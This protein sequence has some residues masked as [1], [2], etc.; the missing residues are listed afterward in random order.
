MSRQEPLEGGIKETLIIALPIVLSQ[1]C[2]T[3]MVLTNR[4][5]L[6]KLGPEL[7]NAALAGGVTAFMAFSFFNGLVGFSTAL[8]A[9]YYGAG[10]KDKCPM[11]TTQALLICLAAFPLLLALHPLVCL[12]FDKMNLPQAQLEPQKQFFSILLYGSCL[13]LWRGCLAAF[14]S[15]IGRTNIVLA[16]SCLAM[17]VNAGVNYILIFGNWG[18]PAMGIRGAAIGELIGSASALAVLAFEYFK[19]KNRQEFSIM[20]SLHFSREVIG[21]L[22]RYGSPT[23]C[24]MFTVLIC[25]NAIILIFDSC[26]SLTATA[27]TIMLNW[28]MV[29][30]VPLIGF[31]IAVTSM[32]GRYMG[33]GKPDSAHKAVISGMKLGQLYSTAVLVLFLV[34]PHVLVDVFRPAGQNELYAQAHPIAV[35]MLRMAAIYVLINAAFVV[36]IGALRGAG[37]TLYAMTV[38]IASHLVIVLA[39]VLVLKVFGRGPIAGWGT[40]IGVFLIFFTVVAKRYWSGKWRSLRVVEGGPGPHSA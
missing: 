5:F 32:V 11:V 34:F 28:D 29:A 10:S 19:Y 15:G 37:D 23:G 25:F 39:L 1:S 35:T 20:K 33:A 36:F 18:F 38:G 4:L 30:F 17:L 3:V 8:V 27:A 14:F 13:P 21:K 12:I 31:E 24:E 26:G 2:D 6:S 16:A 22:L 9:Q 40:L 7:M